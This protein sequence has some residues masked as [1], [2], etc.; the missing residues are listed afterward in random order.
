MTGYKSKKTAALDEDGMYLMHHTAQEPM[1]KLWD[2]PSE[3]FNNWWNS[4]YDDS[5][6]PYI[7]DTYA[8]WAW[9]GWQAALAQPAQEPVAWGFHIQFNNGK[10]ATFKGLDKLAEF[11]ARLEYGE[12]ITLLHTGTPQRP[13]VDLTP[14]DLNAIFAVARTGEDAVHLASDKLKE[15]NT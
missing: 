9:A 3:K 11:E 6:N 12:T 5:T 13:W 14:Q 4:D 1:Q 2:T 8:Y 15:K 7:K 10:D